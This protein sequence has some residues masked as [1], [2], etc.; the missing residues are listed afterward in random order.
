MKAICKPI[1]QKDP[2]KYYPTEVFGKY[3]FTRATCKC[4]TFYWRRTEKADTCGDSK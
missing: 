3:N 4:G 2:S 1:F